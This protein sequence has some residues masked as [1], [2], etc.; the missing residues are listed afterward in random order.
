MWLRASHAVI[1]CV[2]TVFSVP[3]VAEDCPAKEVEYALRGRIEIRDTPMGRGDG[4]YDIGPGRAVLRFEGTTVTML[5]YTMREYFTV[6]SRTAFWKTAVT[7]NT[8]S[9][10]TPDA[11]GVVARGTLVGNTVRWQT[12]VRG[13]RTDGTLTCN[14]S[15]CGDFGVPPPGESQLHIG[16]TPTRFSDFVFSRD[17]KSFTMAMTPATKTEMPKQTSAVTSSGRELRRTCAQPKPCAP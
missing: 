9:S 10:A 11:C 2:A 16:P 1:A 5:S 6:Q 17:M 15:F 12:P 8:H 7:T 3:V 14:G 13:Y 4:T